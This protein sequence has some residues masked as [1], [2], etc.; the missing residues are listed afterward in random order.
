[1]LLIVGI[2]RNGH[3]AFNEPGSSF[4]SRTRIVTLAPET[5]QAAGK[6][7]PHTAI[8]MGIGTIKDSRKI[9]LLA[10]GADKSAIVHRALHGPV[11]EAVPASALQLHSDVIVIMD[12]AA[13]AKKI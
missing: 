9:L 4:D 11:T 13:A 5:I 3:I 10:S 2:G 1:D 6:N 8:T 12:E 7:V